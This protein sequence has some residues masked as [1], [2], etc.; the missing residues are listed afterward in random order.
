MRRINNNSNV[1]KIKLSKIWKLIWV[2][3]IFNAFIILTL[4]IQKQPLLLLMC[5]IINSV[6]IVVLVMNYKKIKGGFS[7][8]GAYT[9]LEK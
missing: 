3:V 6:I 2:L 8:K 9:E 4:I 1:K 7:D 5:L